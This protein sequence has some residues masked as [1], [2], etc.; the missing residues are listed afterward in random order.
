MKRRY[1]NY[2]PEGKEPPPGDLK[3][4]RESDGPLPSRAWFER[5]DNRVR[6]AWTM[7]VEHEQRF[8]T[9]H[10]GGFADLVNLAVE[11]GVAAL[12]RL[13][14]RSSSTISSAS[15]RRLFPTTSRGRRSL[16]A[17]Y[18]EMGRLSPARV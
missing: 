7:T 11:A 10:E 1:A 14:I 4:Q 12:L 9:N 5:A 2:L 13:S 15:L 18:W 16:A 6:G 17:G 3:P 8:A